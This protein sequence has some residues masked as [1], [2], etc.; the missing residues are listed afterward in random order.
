MQTLFEYDQHI[1]DW[2]VL[3]QSRD[4]QNGSIKSRHI[5]DNAVT[6]DKIGDREVK[7]R[8]IAQ[9][10]VTGDKIDG[11]SIIHG[12]IA[13]DAVWARNIKDKEILPEK[14]SDRVIPV[15]IEPLLKPLRDKDED[16]QNQIDSFDE[17]GL[18]V[19]NH[20]GQDPHIGIS[21]KT[22]T[23]AINNI[24]A[25]LEEITGQTFLGYTMEVT[26]GYF[27]SEWPVTVHVSAIPTNQDNIFEHIALYV[28][29]V[30]VVETE[31]VYTFEY[32]IEMSNTSVIRCNATVLGI[33]YIRQKTVN[34]YNS[35]WLGAGSTYQ[36][37][38]DLSHIIPISNGM[39]G[40]YDINVAEG[41]RIIII[42]GDT[43]ASGFFRADMD[44][45][46]IHFN[47]S[48][49][50]VGGHDYKVFTSVNTY[51]AGTYNIDING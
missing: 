5:T 39:R 33:E 2:R 38:M 20:F 48:S 1:G 47:K 27:I 8:N 6:T 32:D 17:H 24:W 28:D 13:D 31:D 41:Q 12:K 36:N 10:A 15:V 3:V 26:P 16:L 19:S 9:E 4:I 42:V 22:L 18:A 45:S 50:T 51:Q 30:L 29:N 34:H 23:Q 35:F 40:A 11:D 25:E 44:G 46:E 37:V 43:L 7:S 14:L 21:Q 49:I